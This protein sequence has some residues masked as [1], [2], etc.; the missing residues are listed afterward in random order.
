VGAISSLCRRSPQSPIAETVSAAVWHGDLAAFRFDVEMLASDPPWRQA[1][2]SYWSH[3]AGVRQ[4]WVDFKESMTTHF[5][6][7]RIVYLKVGRP[8]AGEWIQVLNR[9]GFRDIRFWESR[10]YAGVNAQILAIKD[11][12]LRSLELPME[13]ESR[14]ASTSIADWA[15]SRGVQTVVDP[16]VGVGKMLRK[17]HLAGMRVAGV[18]LIEARARSAAVRLCGAR[19]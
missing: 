19:P 16:C 11:P 10:Y 3:K 12:A 6:G 14:A 17:F 9:C 1:N 7:R 15:A 2:L 18:E 8:E 13:N 5:K 4:R